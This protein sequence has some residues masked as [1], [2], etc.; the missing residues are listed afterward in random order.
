MVGRGDYGL[1][2]F[3]EDVGWLIIKEARTVQQGLHVHCFFFEDTH[4][5]TMS[6]DHCPHLLNRPGGLLIVSLSLSVTHSVTWT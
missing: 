2:V 3:L 4:T 5:H 1:F 6:T